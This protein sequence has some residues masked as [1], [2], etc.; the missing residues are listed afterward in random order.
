MT[1]LESSAMSNVVKNTTMSQ[2]IIRR[3]GNFSP[4]Y[5]QCEIDEELNKFDTAMEHWL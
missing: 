5:K 1:I 3:L 4:E 2:D